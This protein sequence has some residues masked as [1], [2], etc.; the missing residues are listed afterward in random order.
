MYWSVD[1]ALINLKCSHE[2]CVALSVVSVIP[3][4]IMH[5]VNFHAYCKH[6]FKIYDNRLKQYNITFIG[7]FMVW[8]WAFSS[9]TTKEWFGAIKLAISINRKNAAPESVTVVAMSVSGGVS[10]PKICEI[11]FST[12][13][14]AGNF[15]WRLVLFWFKTTV[16]VFSRIQNREKT[17]VWCSMNKL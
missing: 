4:F 13:A 9:V 10:Q 3:S 7:K 14:L 5:L 16:L 15:V 17:F 2:Q 1:M 8:N 11:K 12:H 6:I